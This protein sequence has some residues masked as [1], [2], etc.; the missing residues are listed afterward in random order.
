MR[1]KDMSQSEILNQQ[2]QKITSQLSQCNSVFVQDNLNILVQSDFIVDA[3][4]R[5]PQWLTNIINHPPQ[6]DERRYYQQWLNENLT[7]VWDETALMKALRLFRRYILVRLEWSQLTYTSSDEQILSQLSEL[8]EVIIVT[9]RDWLY[10]L[11]C[12]EWGTPCSH[13]GE[14]QP[15]LVLGMGKLGG[16]E[17]NFSSD[18]D[19]IF[20]YPEHGQTQ[21]GRRELDNA[22]FFTRLGQRLIKALDNITEDGF[23]YRV[24][25]RLRDRKSVV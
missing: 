23:V 17:L 1:E 6:A 16:G 13:Q 20:T 7:S 12:K 11:S 22:V 2:K 3:F 14:P 9:A 18:I 19:L 10:E 24:D 5:Y 4:Y 8:A 25:M 15:L 21:G